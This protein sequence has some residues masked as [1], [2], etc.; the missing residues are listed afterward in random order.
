MLIYIIGTNTYMLSSEIVTLIF[1]R[2]MQINMLPFSFKEYM[3]STGNMN[4]RGIKYVDYL[5][6]NT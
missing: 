1:G 6:W 3:V 2:Y 5:R 4:D